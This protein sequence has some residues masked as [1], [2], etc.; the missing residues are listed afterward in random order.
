[1]MVYKNSAHEVAQQQGPAS[2]KTAGKAPV[3]QIIVL[4]LLVLV[5]IWLIEIR[6][7][8]AHYG[9]LGYTGIFLFTLASN[10][11]LFF[12]VPGPLAAMAGGSLFNPI[13]VALVAATGAT[14]GEM[15]GYVAGVSGKQLIEPKPRLARVKAWMERYGLIPVVVLAAVPNPF[16]DCA[17]I[18][19]GAL[20]IPIPQFL[21]ATWAGKLAKFLAFAYLGAN[22]ASHLGS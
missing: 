12:P 5:T 3:A 22:L 14:L 17:G 13:L 2:K 6:D 18:M 1:M 20:R 21:L 4:A 9:S 16:F 10:A 11:T 7:Q 8:L 15:T 19:A